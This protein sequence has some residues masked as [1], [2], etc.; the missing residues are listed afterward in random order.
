[1]AD[2]EDDLDWSEGERSIESEDLGRSQISG[3]FESVKEQEVPEEVKLLTT[4]PPEFLTQ[5]SNVPSMM[6]V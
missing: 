1:M 5:D 3:L 2:H 4:K 6:V